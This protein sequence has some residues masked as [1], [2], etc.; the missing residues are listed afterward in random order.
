MPQEVTDIDVFR[1]Y[2]RGVVGRADHH[3]R[4]INEVSL[5]VAGGVVWRK[6]DNPLKVMTREGDMKNVLWFKVDGKRYTISYN[7]TTEEIELRV[8]TT[9]GQVVASFSN[10]TS[11]AQVRAAFDGL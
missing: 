6:D 8:G 1:D 9:Q 11:N 3:A 4:K 5:S 2:L 7:H 10:T